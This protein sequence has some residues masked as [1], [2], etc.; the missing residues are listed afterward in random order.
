[1]ISA[2]RD[3]GNTTLKEFDLIIVGGGVYG[4]MLSLE[5]GL[6]GKRA[7]LIEKNDFGAATTYNHLRTLHGGLRY[8][9]SLDLKRFFESV[10]ERQWF[11]KNFPQFVKV[12]PCLMPLYDKGVRR[13]SI[14]NGAIWIN[15]RLSSWRNDGVVPE[16]HLPDG[17]IVNPEEVK[18]IYPGVATDGLTGGGIWYDGMVMEPERLMSGLINWSQSLGASLL[19]Y[20]SAQEIIKYN[21]KV[22][23]VQATDNESGTTVEFNAPVV[24]NAAGPWCR[25][26]SRKFDRDFS[27]LFPTG[28]RLWNILFKR[29]SLSTYSLA[30]SAQ[31]GKGHTYFVHDWKGRMLTGTGEAL[32]GNMETDGV[33]TSRQI[34]EFLVDLN[35]AVPALNLSVED[36]D[37]IYSGILPATKKGKLSKRETII[38]HA[39]SGGPKG[40]FSIS[41][42]KFTTSRLV[43]EKTIEK[44]FPGEKREEPVQAAPADVS[45]ARQSIFPFNWLPDKGDEP[46][47]DC[48][49]NSIHNEW[50]VH[51]DDLVFR[52]TSL[53]ENPER[54]VK[55][56]PHLR[57]LFPYDDRRWQEE[58]KRLPDK[59]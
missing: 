17:R 58:L 4:L 48:L 19:N 50:V 15:D 23:G 59:R 14:L 46:W 21:G 8:L 55:I 52:R 10:R 37:H 43:A 29:E 5:A 51:V 31:Q 24:I 16:K 54:L 12:L 57:E 41:G 39:A 6:R 45:D 22:T 7:L 44:V 25:D 53:G 11:F 33:P 34:N 49:R 28:L 1:M 18:T 47:K 38:D 40:L 3:V 9:Q 32:V 13:R 36:I 42:V 35:S 30:I 20:V 27:V 26:V 56:I 2:Q